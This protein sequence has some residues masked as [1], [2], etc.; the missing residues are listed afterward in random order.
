MSKPSVA[1]KCS[2]RVWNFPKTDLA[3]GG[4]L[5]LWS[6]RIA[7]VIYRQISMTIITVNLPCKPP[8]FIYKNAFCIK[9]E[10]KG[11]RRTSFSLTQNKR[12]GSHSMITFEAVFNSKCNF[13]SEDIGIVWDESFPAQKF[14]QVSSLPVLNSRRSCYSITYQSDTPQNRLWTRSVN[15]KKAERYFA[16][17][18]S[19]K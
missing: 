19:A 1:S 10:E 4:P 9:D 6:Y 2:K 15:S 8:L 14:P 18:V 17:E 11:T 7:K 13:T 3:T 5:Q 16:I 12:S